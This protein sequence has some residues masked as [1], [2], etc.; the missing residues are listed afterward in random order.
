MGTVTKLSALIILCLLAGCSGNQQS[1]LDGVLQKAGDNR[2]ELTAVLEH[3]RE[4]GDPLRLEAA[5]FLI[6]NMER[7][8]FVEAVFYDEAENEIA[9]DALDY[10]N[11][12]AALAAVDSLEAIYG[13]IDYGRKRFDPDVEIITAEFLIENIELA[14]RAWIEKPW[15]SE[16][17][18]DSFCEFILPYRGS[19]EPLSSWRRACYHQLAPLSQEM[20]DPV[21]PAEAGR[22]IRE[23]V[24]DWVR[25]SELYYLH[26]TDQSYDEMMESGYGRCEDIGNMMSYAMRANAVL[27]ANDYTPHW[28]NRDNNHAWEVILNGDGVGRGGL[29]NVAA[30]IYRKM[31][32]IQPGNLGCIIEKDETVPRWLA[33]K[34]YRDVTDQYMETTDVTITLTEIPPEKTR[35]AYLCVFN[36]GEWAAIHWSRIDNNTATFDRMG[37]DIAYSPAYFQNDQLIPA[38]APFILTAAGEVRLLATDQTEVMELT[39]SATTP[40]IPDADTHS[41]RPAVNVTSGETYELFYWRNDWFSL[42]KQL[43]SNNH[44]V[45]YSD[46]PTGGLYWLVA[47]NSRRLER[48]F[49]VENRQQT[50]W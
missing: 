5:K 48:I 32:S 19:N 38:A 35:F 9:F 4:L 31:F 39:I 21:D 16:I 7:H 15:A 47:E 44:S 27:S 1:A 23:A 18:F 43:A 37:R 22:R 33:G 25:F 24:R 10:E 2:D 29:E 42:G 12:A 6:Q 50:W 34:T 46:V 40:N 11:Y 3:Y 14:F 45:T 26:P 41:V 13:S 30:K 17:N 36:G 49:T 28:A 20:T 8:G